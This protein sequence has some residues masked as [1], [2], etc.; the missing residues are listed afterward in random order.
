LSVSVS[1]RPRLLSLDV[2]RGFVIVSMLFV[3]LLSDMPEAPRFLVHAP[4]EADAYTYADLVF[5]G[6]LF[7][8]GVAIPLS[9]GGLAEAAHGRAAA[10]TRVLLRAFSLLL[11]GVVLEFHRDLD[12]S[13]TVL[14]ELHWTSLF[15]VGLM[16][17]WQVEPQGASPAR[18]KRWQLLRG[19]GALLIVV[20]LALF[21]GPDGE[22]GEPTWLRTQWW[23]ILGMIGWAYLH[24]SSVYLLVRG[25]DLWLWLSFALMLALYVVLRQGGVAY[26]PHALNDFVAVG[27]VLGS[28]SANVMAGV[29]VGNRFVRHASAPARTQLTFMA[30]FALGMFAAGTLLRPL[31]GINKIA[32]TESYT[33][34]A[35]GLCCAVF[36]LLYWLVDMRGHGR[37]V[38]SLS[39]LGQ[40]ALLAYIM[41]SMVAYA[42]RLVG[43]YE[44]W[45]R[46]A[47]PFY[48]SAAPLACLNALVVTLFFS[49]LV[50]VLGRA[51]LR[52]RF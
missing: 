10:L 6:F 51:G 26:V 25:R 48:R 14:S 46:H 28:T 27:P 2:F 52:L 19:A 49:A 47:Y 18:R 23:G 29:L 39:E 33:L 50:V 35:A 9:L 38:G 24:A 4:S 15:F 22:D 3:N 31:H 42:L 20:L 36:A 43:L 16:L 17:A 32:A 45:E 44:A 30:L 34:V 11:A 41:P 8:V 1:S 21:R 12:E 13:N 7:M 5:P 37:R 40:N